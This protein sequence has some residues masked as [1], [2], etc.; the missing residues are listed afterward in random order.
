MQAFSYSLQMAAVGQSFAI[1]FALCTAVNGFSY[2]LSLF[3]GP[4]EVECFYQHV[5]VTNVYLEID[6]Q[7]T[8]RV[9]L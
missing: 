8:C 3:I 9:N 6:Y 4:G 5:H 1:L 7:V 2:E